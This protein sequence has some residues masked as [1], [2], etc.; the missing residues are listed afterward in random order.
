MRKRYDSHAKPAPWHRRP[1]EVRAAIQNRRP[2]GLGS[3]L[4]RGLA[5]VP[6]ADWVGREA[7][8]VKNRQ[9]LEQDFPGFFTTRFF[10]RLPRLGGR[11]EGEVRRFVPK[12]PFVSSSGI[13]WNSLAVKKFKKGARSN[14]QN[15]ARTLYS[16]NLMMKYLSSTGRLPK[17]DFEIRIPE[18][19][20]IKGPFLVMRD[21]SGERLVVADKLTPS[22]FEAD[23]KST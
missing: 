1:K 22:H 11:G 23:R 4:G 13:K 14:P 10:S 21:L 2:K 15:Q 18:A 6:A 7:R 12:E 16:L 8:W 17:A 20:T 3:R 5:P 9:T 19:I